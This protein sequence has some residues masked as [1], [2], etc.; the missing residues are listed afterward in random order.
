MPN[1]NEIDRCGIWK[2]LGVTEC[3]GC[4]THDKCWG[5]NAKC[6]ISC[7]SCQA[8]CSHRDKPYLPIEEPVKLRWSNRLS[9]EVK[10]DET[11]QI[12]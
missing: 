9:E 11:L 2:V 10:E 5:E 3:N 7:E 4:N 1:W 12:R 6:L 8:K